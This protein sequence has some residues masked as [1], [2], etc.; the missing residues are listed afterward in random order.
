MGPDP[1][2]ELSSPLATIET[3]VVSVPLKPRIVTANYTIETIELVVVR[4]HDRD[5]ARGEATLW[6]F[7]APQARVL[8]EA[9][10]YLA[11]FAA[12]GRKLAEI[13]AELRR[14]INFFGFKGVIVFALSALDMALHDLALRAR[15]ENVAML[16]GRRR[17]RVPAYW[18]GLFLNQSTAELVA[19]VEERAEQ[20]FRAFKVRTGAASLDADV[21]RVRAVRDAMPRGSV[22]MLDAVQSWDVERALAAAE[23]LA[24]FEPIWLE[25][26]L[27]HADYTGLATVVERS[28]IP[29]A[30]GE[31]EYLR[32]GFEQLFSTS[33]PYLLADLQRVGGV[34]EWR[35]V[36]RRATALGTIV[37]PHVYPHIA[38][39]LCAGL[40]Q[41]EAWIE[42][43]PWWDEL[44][45]DPLRFE[46]GA[47]VVPEGPGLGGS[48]DD[49]A[50]ERAALGPWE[51][52]A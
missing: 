5:G 24:E 26:P 40:E 39:G 45:R 44:L 9:L 13:T 47:V 29:I 52:C 38:A 18:S 28:P 43:I 36:A 21:T 6:C 42:Y 7:G 51:A 35:A 2:L 49:D 16:V 22:L 46:D 37:T 31:N 32:E 19:E 11:P 12:R 15:G 34:T 14:E 1:T 48:L 27:A 10:R 8:T 4:A 50:V 25:D 17:D 3:R 33:V 23:R 30:T 41:D 20:G